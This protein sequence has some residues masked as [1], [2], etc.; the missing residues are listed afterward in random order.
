M[1]YQMPDGTTYTTPQPGQAPALG[2][3][4]MIPDGRAAVILSPDTHGWILARPWDA[5]SPLDFRTA[6]IQPWEDPEA[7]AVA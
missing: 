6:D 1:T 2:D 5:G 4:V 3:V 7:I